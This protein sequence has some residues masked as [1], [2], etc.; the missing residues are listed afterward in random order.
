MYRRTTSSETAPIGQ[1]RSMERHGG[2][3][4]LVV[5]DSDSP[6]QIRLPMGQGY[7][8][9]ISRYGGVRSCIWLNSECT[10]ILG[11]E[12]VSYNSVFSLSES[13][14]ASSPDIRN[15]RRDTERVTFDGSAQYRRYTPTIRG[16]I[17]RFGIRVVRRTRSQQASQCGFSRRGPLLCVH[18]TT[19]VTFRMSK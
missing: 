5:S 12:S 18:P 1:R 7:T 15:L 4:L 14:D 2:V 16:C 6:V 19:D 10:L 8:R 3:S 17:G 9:L 11:P 13:R